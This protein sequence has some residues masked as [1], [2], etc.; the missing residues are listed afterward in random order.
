MSLRSK[1][2][3]EIF[4]KTALFTCGIV[5]ILV[6]FAVTTFMTASGIPG[7]REIGLRNFLL[8]DVWCPAGDSPSFSILPFILTSIFG[9][10]GAL[11]IGAPIGLLTAIFLSKFASPKAASVLN[12]VVELLAGIPSVVYGFVGLTL[13]VPLVQQAFNLASGATLFSAIV[14]LGIMILPSIINVSRMALDAVPIDV[15]EASYAL[16]ATKTETIFKVSVPSAKSGIAAGI[17]LGVGRAM[18]EAMAVMMVAGN[19]ANMPSLFNSV[20][21]LTTAITREMNY[22]SGLQRDAL[23]SI[24]VVLFAFITI[25]NLSLNFAL[26]RGLKNDKA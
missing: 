4:A 9:T 14:V 10:L 18:G 7:I 23:F 3:T 5:T 1:N 12:T 22:A 6:V 19:V 20:T 2:I 8:G 11:I 24:G 13:L 26:K 25:I 17:V 21:F 15:E 16:G